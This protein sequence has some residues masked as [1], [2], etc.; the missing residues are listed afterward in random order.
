MTGM[1]APPLRKLMGETLAMRRRFLFSGLKEAGPRACEAGKPVLIF[2][3]FMVH[4]VFCERLRSS[5]ELAGYDARTWGMGLNRGL[6]PE[7]LERLQDLVL[8]V[9]KETGQK[10]SLVGWSL[11][12]L[13]ARELAK[14]QP[15]SVERVVTLA[16]P[17]SGNPR[18]NNV[19]RIYEW[20]AGH[21]V[22]QPPIDICLHEKPPVPTFAL[23]SPKDGVV[24]PECCKGAQGECDWDISVDCNHTD[25]VSNRRGITATLEALSQQIG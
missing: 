21:P 24:A 10:V 7:M 16:S 20:A 5:L 23:W 11:G 18:A 6:R 25:F 1:T 17:F 15:T 14:L 4:E 19:W 22:D 12:G 13:F 9:H 2:P 3:A 8:N